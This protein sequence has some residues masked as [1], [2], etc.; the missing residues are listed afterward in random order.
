[1]RDLILHHLELQYQI[2]SPWSSSSAATFS[3]DTFFESSLSSGFAIAVEEESASTAL[4]E[5][6]S[7]VESS[8][9]AD[10]SFAS[11]STGAAW[12]LLKFAQAPI[13]AFTK[14]RASWGK[15]YVRGTGA[16][17]SSVLQSVPSVFSFL[18]DAP[19]DPCSSSSSDFA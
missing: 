17:S 12:R 13:K 2:S 19:E 1:M 16:T 3:F 7:F 5:P 14:T 9:A 11:P 8:F 18:A 6:S 10:A 15:R 4:S